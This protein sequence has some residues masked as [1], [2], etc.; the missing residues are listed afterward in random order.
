MFR[1]IASKKYLWGALSLPLIFLCIEF[2]DELHYGITSAALPNIRADLALSYAQIGLLLGLPH[3]VGTLVEPVLMLLGDTPLRKRLIIV[4]GLGLLVSLGLTASARSFPVLLLA[5]L[6]SFPASGAFVTLAQATLMDLNHGRESQWMAR[7]TAAGSVG[8]LLGPLLVSASLAL[9]LGWRW[10]FY[11]IAGLV[12]FLVLAVQL[13]RFPAP[14]IQQGS[15]EERLSPRGLFNNLWTAVRNR[16][17]LRWVLLLELSDLLLDIFAGY[18]ALYFTDVAGATP[19]QAASFLT[20]LML[21]GLVADL[22]LI[23]LLERVPGRSLVRASAALA[24]LVYSA[25]LLVPW[26]AAKVILLVL[27]RFTTI[28]WYAVLQGEAYASA[29]GRSGAVM[30]ITSL[31]GI[32]S[33]GLAWLVG[34]LAGAAGLPAA[35]WLLLLGPLSLFLFVPPHLAGTQGFK[36]EEVEEL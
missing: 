32:V 26:L 7:W 19:A 29:P 28:G 23:P 14:V 20:V 4:G 17:L 21:A 8:N 27:I 33:G 24:I 11:G 9:A 5:F 31:A 10:L 1:F 12:L 6:V 34:W 3:V 30:A 35:M 22:I 25:W 16:S 18:T 36:A 15:D 13:I 2:F